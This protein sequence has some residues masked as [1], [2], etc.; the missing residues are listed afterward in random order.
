MKEVKKIPGD[1]RLLRRVFYGLLLLVCC[2]LQACKKVEKQDTS[3]AYDPNSP[4]TYKDYY[5]K[6]GGVSTQMIIEGA[7]FGTDTALIRVY[8]NDK[9]AAVI[10]VN[11][12]HIYA[13]VPPRAGTG[14]V[15]VVVGKENHDKEYSFPDPF[16][17]EFKHQV[18]TIAGQ[19]DN[20]GNGKDQDG[21]YSSAW[22]DS[23]NW[24]LFD[25]DGA[26]YVL[27]PG[28]LRK[29][30]KDQV[31]TLLKKSGPFERMRTLKFNLAEDTLY[32][33]ND[34]GNATGLGTA[35]LFRNNGFSTYK[36]YIY[37]RQT[38]FGTVHPKTGDYFYNRFQ[39]GMLFRFDKATNLPVEQFRIKDND[40]E[41]SM[42]FT[43][44]GN[45]AYI[46]VRNK[47]YIVKAEYNPATKRLENP[48]DW[49]GGINISD[50]K[51]G[52]GMEA[53]FE[54]PC[55]GAIDED[56]NLYVADKNNHCIR[57]ITVDGVVSV[58]AGIPKQAGYVDGEPLK[59]QFRSPE[60][61]AFGPDGGLYVADFG[62]HRIRR[63]LVE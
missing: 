40:W 20:N 32:I 19:T 47:N 33:T 62:N 9:R 14:K 45:T 43:T 4:V 59:S 31:T 60:G 38:N 12:T 35:V 2:S 26:L 50:F 48:L 27:Q 52:I 11:G 53:R 22:F 8:V 15:K 16:D 56:G 5:P 17:Y 41:Y 36:P 63:I 18:S 28:A 24:L 25:K 1:I 39:D 49:A 46:I 3:T 30:Y 23:P 6:N 42:L 55:Q 61:V 10:G 44:D 29:L 57:K 13:L 21:T 7:N 54:R 37:S 34:Q 51:N 58:Y